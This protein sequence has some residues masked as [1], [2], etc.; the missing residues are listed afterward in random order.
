MATTTSKLEMSLDQI[1]DAQKRKGQTAGKK[2]MGGNGGARKVFAKKRQQNNR[3]SKFKR[4]SGRLGRVARFGN[5]KKSTAGAMQK[6]IVVA[7]SQTFANVKNARIQKNRNMMKVTKN[8]V[9]KLVK[10]AIAQNL[11]TVPVSISPSKRQMRVRANRLRQ[12]NILSR[13]N[14]QSRIIGRRRIIANN[15]PIMATRRVNTDRGPIR[16]NAQLPAF[17]HVVSLPPRIVSSKPQKI[18]LQPQTSS[19]FTTPRRQQISFNGQN[20]SQGSSVRAQINAMRR[21]SRVQQLQN[22]FAKQQQPTQKFIVQQPRAGR[23]VQQVILSRPPRRTQY[24]LVQQQS[25]GQKFGQIPN[26]NSNTKRFV[27]RQ[28]F[29][30]RMRGQARGQKFSVVDT[31]YEPPNFL[32]RI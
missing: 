22:Q 3:V 29:F 21:A 28:Q 25:R 18:V 8:L 27:R 24:I 5:K 23:R 17:Q 7:K 15:S 32:Q 30:G 14:V 2:P 19:L 31:F 26:N 9:R 6:R 20:A 10:K 12:R 13:V 4:N 1:I 16:F 11:T